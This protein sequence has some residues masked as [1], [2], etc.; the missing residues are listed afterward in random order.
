ML[1]YIF[2]FE[3]S[4]QRI[5]TFMNYNFM[6]ICNYFCFTYK[7]QYLKTVKISF[8]TISIQKNQLILLQYLYKKCM[9]SIKL[10]MIS[11]VIDGHKTSVLC[12]RP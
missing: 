6:H 7:L 10:A 12:L 4:D 2:L 3:I 8:C 11:K 5:N 1:K 9:N